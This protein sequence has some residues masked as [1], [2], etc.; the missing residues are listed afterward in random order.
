VIVVVVVVVVAA[1]AM[2][3][4]LVVVLLLVGFVPRALQLLQWH[5]LDCGPSHLYA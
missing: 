5:Y 2:V 4:V 1:A 3:V